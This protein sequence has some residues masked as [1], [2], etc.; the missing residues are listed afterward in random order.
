MSISVYNELIW[1]QWN[2][3]ARQPYRTVLFRKCEAD[4]QTFKFYAVI[5]IMH[6]WMNEVCKICIALA[7]IFNIYSNCSVTVVCSMRSHFNLPCVVRKPTDEMDIKCLCG[8]HG[9][10]KD[11]TMT[12]N[13]KVNLKI[14]YATDKLEN[15]YA[16]RIYANSNANRKCWLVYNW[17]YNG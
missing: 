5:S 14:I 6:E 15:R 10:K 2:V 1:R 13:N 12:K 11:R 7:H 3:H 16:M 8:A 4:D 9:P 17:I